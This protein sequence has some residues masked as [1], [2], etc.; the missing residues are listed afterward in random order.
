MFRKSVFTFD[1]LAEGDDVGPELLPRRSLLL[2]QGGQRLLV[3]QRGQVGV[4]LPVRELLL[5]RWTSFL[6]FLGERG[7][8]GE[9]SAQPVEGLLAEAGALLVV[10]LSGVGALACG[11]Q[12]GGTGGAG[13]VRGLP[14]VG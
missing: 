6:A 4:L 7:V 11:G 10:E 9:V 12:C 13:A 2:G 8:G 1:L 3:A 14:P 5:D